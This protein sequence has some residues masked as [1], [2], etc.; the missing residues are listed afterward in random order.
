MNRVVAYDLL[1]A[2]LSSY[3]DFT[4]EELANLAGKQSF[5]TKRGTDGVDYLVETT[6]ARTTGKEAG[7]RVSGSVTPADWGAPHDRL[8]ESFVV[9]IYPGS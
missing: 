6:V 5:A 2:A 9:P 3:K 7:I 8:E 4:A 1:T